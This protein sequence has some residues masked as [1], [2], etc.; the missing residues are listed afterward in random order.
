MSYRSGDVTVS[1]PVSYTR[2]PSPNSSSGPSASSSGAAGS[3]SAGASSSVSSSL[4]R[5]SSSRFSSSAS[6]YRTASM[7]RPYQAYSILSS[8]PPRPSVSISDRTSSLRFGL[9]SS[10]SSYSTSSYSSGALARR[11]SPS[12]S[13]A[14]TTTSSYGSYTAR[15][16][17]TDSGL[18]ESRA[19]SRERSEARTDTS[20][21]S[22]SYSSYRIRDTSRTR[23]PPSTYTSTY[24]TGR[25]NSL[26]TSPSSASSTGSSA[27][28]RI[29]SRSYLNSTSDLGA[30]TSSSTSTSA[31]TRR[32]RIG[33]SSSLAD[34][35]SSSP[36]PSS[37]SSGTEAR[38]I[39]GSCGRREVNISGESFR[40]EDAK[41]VSCISETN[42]VAD[43]AASTAEDGGDDNGNRLS[44]AEIRRLF[45]ANQNPAPAR[46]AVVAGASTAAGK[47]RRSQEEDDDDDDEEE[48][49]EEEDEEEEESDGEAAG[50]PVARRSRAGAAAA[51]ASA[52]ASSPSSS[53]AHSTASSSSS[54]SSSSVLSPVRGGGGLDG[55]DENNVITA[56]PR[57][58]SKAVRNNTAEN[59][60]LLGLRNLGNT[61]FMNSVL[62]CLSNTRPL[63]EYILGDNYSSDLN[64]TNSSMKGALI[65]AF[66]TVI[67]ELWGYP[68]G[69]STLCTAVNT[70]ALKAQLQRFAPR[71]TGY[72]QQDAQEFLRY[73]LEGLHE[74]VNRVVTKPSS[75]PIL[76]D[77]DP[78]L[79]D[80]QKAMEAWK[81]YL[82][83][84]NSKIVD[85]FVGQLKSTLQCTVCG[86][87]SVTFDPF[88]DLSLP[89]PPRT[90]QVR[91]QQCF[92]LFTKEEVLDGEEK[93]TCSKC[94][95]RR[96]CTKS[97]S[98]QKFPRILVLHLK[99][100]S[101]ME[102]FRGKLNCNVD[103]PL[104][105]LDLSAYAASRGQ[106][107]VYNAYGVAN[108]SGTTYSGHYTA[109]C[110]HPYNGD[111]HEYNDSR[112]ST[113]SP[114]N[115]VTNEA[116]VL[117]YELVGHSSHL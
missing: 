114:R 5:S 78:S 97:F 99:R 67:Q 106:G 75:R 64:T 6:H 72:S 9:P 14:S 113:V 12:R 26:R 102:R 25:S 42:G 19:G 39:G 79:S 11:G 54:S 27:S 117:F 71:F 8:R 58:S 87:C 104:T 110:K 103:F 50:S 60:G 73:L 41:S 46:P 81:R 85:I 51:A 59:G 30:S 29:H 80:N 61:C 7:E 1:E 82:R 16:L 95:V 109:Y 32:S 96:K 40:K 17:S 65:K 66:S 21:S 34:A 74:D 23:D 15:K 45:D 10:T 89:I 53:S 86:H 115:V 18:G 84:D 38:A 101:P 69:S 43:S 48:D 57:L 3:S 36:T 49:D 107:C 13:T 116:Y 105:G 93:P 111:W 55:P 4:S 112:V 90:G 52:S 68:E 92:D 22:S 24:G 37:I 91:L 35:K 98:I 94:Q 62:Q 44:V 77:V 108:H 83:M 33:S 20:T 56:S 47:G 63:L 88:W 70:T 76:P 31:L 28:S 2:M 100:F